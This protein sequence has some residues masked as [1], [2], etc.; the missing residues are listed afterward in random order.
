MT[1]TDTV[2]LL[3]P[4]RGERVLLVLPDIDAAALAHVHV[5]GREVG[6]LAWPPFEIE[7]TDHV[8]AGA[9]EIAVTLTGTL[10]NLLGPHH[11]PQ[12]EPD[13]C[14]TDDYLC[15]P[16]WL[17]DPETLAAR[18]TGDYTFLPFG[19]QPGAYVRILAPSPH[20]EEPS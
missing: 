11:R 20:K 14:W 13:Q 18:W 10:R 17:E 8:R 9:N 12:G 16:E 6:V 19:L 7:I 5:N 3:A 2:D 15:P 4:L 1:L